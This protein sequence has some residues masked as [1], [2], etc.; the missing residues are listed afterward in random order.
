MIH[1][2]IFCLYQGENWT[3]GGMGIYSDFTTCNC[4]CPIPASYTS[5]ATHSILQLDTSGSVLLLY[6]TMVPENKFIRCT[7]VSVN[8]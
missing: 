3:T 7:K 8:V 5:M 1:T 2:K 6:T 4:N